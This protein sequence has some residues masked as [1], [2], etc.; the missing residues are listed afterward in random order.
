MRRRVSFHL[1]PPEVLILT[2]SYVCNPYRLV[3]VSKRLMTALQDAPELWEGFQSWK[4]FV[5]HRRKLAMRKLEKV[6]RFV[7]RSDLPDLLKRVCHLDLC[8]WEIEID[9]KKLPLKS[10]MLTDLAVSFRLVFS[11]IKIRAASMVVVTARSTLLNQRK[12]WP[13]QGGSLQTG[14]WD[15]SS[16]ACLLVTLPVADIL[17]SFEAFLPPMNICPGIENERLQLELAIRAGD[18]SSLVLREVFTGIRCKAGVFTA[19]EAESGRLAE[20]VIDQKPMISVKCGAAQFKWDMAVIDIC[21]F[22][23]AWPQAPYLALS[24]FAIVKHV[25]ALH[26]D[27]KDVRSIQVRKGSVLF[28]LEIGIDVDD[29][30]VLKRLVF[31]QT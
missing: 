28:D 18:G 8:E 21:L 19:F 15:D 27:Y 4:G 5:D 25:H 30:L 2:A 10:P 6:R 29:R 24:E 7:K 3:Q 14:F 17:T 22:C 26:F 16:V 31:S 13:L 23:E 12:S 9:G 1:L 11:T 20:I